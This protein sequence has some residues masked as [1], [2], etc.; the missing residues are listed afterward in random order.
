MLQNLLEKK[1]L[2]LQMKCSVCSVT[3]VISFFKPDFPYQLKKKKKKKEG[4]GG[5]DK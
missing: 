3:L 1:R 5:E 2:Q 4:E